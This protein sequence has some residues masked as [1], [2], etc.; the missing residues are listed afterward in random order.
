MTDKL[1]EPPPVTEATCGS[2]NTK[3]SASVTVSVPEMTPPL[4][5]PAKLIVFVTAPVPAGVLLT[6]VWPLNARF[7]DVPVTG[8]F[9]SNPTVPNVDVQSG[10]CV[11][12]VP[13]CVP[14]VTPV[15]VTV[16]SDACVKVMLKVPLKTL[17]NWHVLVGLV[18]GTMVSVTVIWPLTGPEYVCGVGVALVGLLEPVQETASA[19]RRTRTKSCFM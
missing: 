11:M 16:P 4:S 17:R 6:T 5:A 3:L 7:A 13:V 14:V 1:V 10:D 19:A 8:R 15:P 18:V 2:G 12:A 9:Q